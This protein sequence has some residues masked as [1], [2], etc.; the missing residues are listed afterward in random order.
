MRRI[1]KDCFCLFFST[2]PFSLKCSAALLLALFVLVSQPKTAR[3]E[4]ED[5][6]HKASHAVDNVKHEALH[7]KSHGH[8]EGRSSKHLA[9]AEHKKAHAPAVGHAKTHESSGEHEG[10]FTMNVIH[11][12]FLM[13]LF[14]T[15]V[16]VLIEKFAHENEVEV[17]KNLGALVFMVIFFYTFEQMPGIAHYHDAPSLGFLKFI[18]KMLTGAI[19]TIIGILCMHEHHDEDAHE[20]GAHH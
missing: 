16:N 5:H 17:T 19:L 15:A 11:W 7:V 10:S 3:C 20:N 18:I 9:P 13:F 8:G 2:F 1:N 12:I 6:Q 14:F 4:V